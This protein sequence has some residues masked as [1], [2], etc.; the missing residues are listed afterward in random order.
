MYLYFFVFF[1][2]FLSV[3]VFAPA[4]KITLGKLKYNMHMEYEWLGPP[5]TYLGGSGGRRRDFPQLHILQAQLVGDSA[6]QRLCDGKMRIPTLAT[7]R[8]SQ[9]NQQYH[10]RG[11]GSY[12]PKMDGP[13]E[14]GWG[15]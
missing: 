5:G 6:Q 2:H 12:L 15:K 11:G 4:N 3:A 10:P 7:S 9:I 1:S 14:Y 13:W 8:D